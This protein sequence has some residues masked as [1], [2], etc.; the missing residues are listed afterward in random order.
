[1]IDKKRSNIWS[2]SYQMKSTIF[3]FQA[4]TKE[5]QNATIIS[6]NTFELKQSNAEL[7]KLE[8]VEI[9]HKSNTAG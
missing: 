5:V 4:S 9:S 8:R 1:M 6:S 3:A 7:E 2:P